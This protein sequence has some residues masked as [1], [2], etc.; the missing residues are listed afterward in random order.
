MNLLSQTV[1]LVFLA[2]LRPEAIDALKPHVPLISESSRNVFA[3]SVVKAIAQKV[4]DPH[5]AKEL[6]TSGKSLFKAGI[7]SFDYDDEFW[8][9]HPKPNYVPLP[10]SLFFDMGGDEVMLNPQ[11]LPP[12]EQSYYGALLTMLA[13][14]I[15]VE[16]TSE[17]LHD[18]GMSLMKQTTRVHEKY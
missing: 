3:A 10:G 7:Q 16:N 9:L 14:T 12:H 15:S 6:N 5:V 2:H 1:E 13:E 17:T 11:P 18:I 4:K 8:P